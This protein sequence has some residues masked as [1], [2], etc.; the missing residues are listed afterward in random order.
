MTPSSIIFFIFAL[1]FLVAFIQVG[2]LTIAFEKL[3]LSQESAFLL[4][5]SS[6]MGSMVNLP[7]FRMRSDPPSRAQNYPIMPR[8]LQPKLEYNGRTLI[9]VNVGGGVIPI[10]FSLYLMQHNPIGLL[11]ILLGVGGVGTIS[12]LFSRPIPG[13]GIG[14][15][16][17][18]A[19]LA[20]ALVALVLN[21]EQSAPLAYISGTLGVLIGADLMRFSDIRRL[22]APLASIG[23][24]GTFDG[25]FIT[26]IVAVLLA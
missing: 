24:A 22:G 6:L 1:T 11:E 13:V 5:F 20:A 16:I 7:L 12:Y 19:P 25:I 26:G 23:G 17:L 14:M 18:I 9:A 15:P 10:L 2:L 21:P 4:L 3:G 8:W